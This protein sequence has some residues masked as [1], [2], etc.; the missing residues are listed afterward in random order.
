[1]TMMVK[2]LELTGYLSEK[3]RRHYFSAIV[4]PLTMK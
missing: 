4:E 1:M 2:I 3:N